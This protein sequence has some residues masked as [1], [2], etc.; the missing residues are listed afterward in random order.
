M[1][2]YEENISPGLLPQGS[3]VNYLDTFAERAATVAIT[4]GNT[5]ITQVVLSIPLPALV[6]AKSILKIKAHFEVTNSHAYNLGVGRY[7]I[8]GTSAT[9]A[10][11]VTPG[12]VTSYVYNPVEDNC[13]PANH[14]WVVEMSQDYLVPIDI[15]NGFLN[16]VTY[17]VNSGVIGG[18]TMKI[19]Q[20]YSSMS[21]TIQPQAQISGN[22]SVV[23]DWLSFLPVQ[24]SS[25][26]ISALN[27]MLEGIKSDSNW[28]FDKFNIHATEHQ[29]DAKV[30][31]VFPGFSQAIEVGSPTWTANQGYTVASGKYINLNF[32]PST[33]GYWFSQDSATI[34]IYSRTN[35]N[36][37]AFDIGSCDVGQAH[38]TAIASKY[39]DNKSY[40]SINDSNGNPI[41]TTVT[42][43]LGLF[44]GQRSNA[45]QVKDYHRGTL[46]STKA[47]NST[48]VAGKSL[49]LGEWN[50]NGSV[51][52]TTNR[53]YA[54]S[55]I[56][57][58]GINIPNL[59]TRIQTFM[60]AIGA[61]V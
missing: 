29:A 59:Y 57:G 39:S 38:V 27:N 44:V 18:D 22:D 4:D 40:T 41:G 45:T 61:N 23:N 28:L 50:N 46:L 54:M 24:P 60:T 52:G 55:F 42:D 3:F 13:A 6:K 51:T 10:N 47:E 5:Y 30:S 7:I 2:S 58:G 43:S 25:T 56:G 31:L 49:F 16:V 34:G 53:Q 8:I 17:A 48:G 1:S 33:D 19:E 36:T 21:C 37:A 11:F 12:G 15:T 14:H 35:N 9:D 20:G 32:V 26:F